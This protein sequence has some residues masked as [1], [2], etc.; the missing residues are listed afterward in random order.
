MAHGAKGYQIV[1]GDQRGGRFSGGQAA[2][3]LG[4]A[5][6]AVLRQIA[7]LGM[8][9]A[10]SGQ[11]QPFHFIIEGALTDAAGAYIGGAAN[12]GDAPVPQRIQVGQALAHGHGQ[13][14]G[15]VDAGKALDPKA[16]G[17]QRHDLLQAQK[18]VQHLLVAAFHHAAHQHRALQLLLDEPVDHGPGVAAAQGHGVHLQGV[19]VAPGFLFGTGSQS[20]KI[21]IGQLGY[22]QRKAA[23][24]F[25]FLLM[26]G[27]GGGG[28][29]EGFH[30]F[31]HLFAGC[32][33][34]AAPGH[35]PGYRSDGNARR[36]RHIIDGCLFFAH[37]ANPVLW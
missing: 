37:G 7:G 24:A 5:D 6:L 11:A 2:E 30:G 13:V 21:G 33:A 34:H 14:G 1:D 8:E 35:H 22:H 20:S 12:E 3:Q 31:L 16:D 10:V 28:I 32:R 9:A 15:D 25:L 19:A 27:R 4:H 26:A 18:V 36:F 23:L 29:A 17:H